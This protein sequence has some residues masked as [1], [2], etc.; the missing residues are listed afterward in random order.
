MFNLNRLKNFLP[1]FLN[2][3]QYLKNKKLL[4]IENEKKLFK[5]NYEQ[6]IYK[7][8]ETI[9]EKKEISFLHSGHAGDMVLAFPVIKE[10]SKTHRCKLFIQ[11]NQEMSTYY[12][13][14]PVISFCL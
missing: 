3:N 11:L 13:N 8:Q 5:E 10:L 6:Y 9:R 14:H 1:K 12:E 4:Q 7:I 2:K